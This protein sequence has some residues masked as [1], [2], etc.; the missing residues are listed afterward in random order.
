MSPLHLKPFWQEKEKVTD[1]PAREAQG[2]SDFYRRVT[3]AAIVVVS[4]DSEG[5]ALT[6]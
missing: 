3:V 4:L 5:S 1:G 6:Q 2:W